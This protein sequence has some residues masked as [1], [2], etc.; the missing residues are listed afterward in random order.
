MGSGDDNIGERGEG[1]GRED[2]L[3]ADTLGLDNLV[4]KGAGES[5]DGAFGRGVVKE[6][7][8]QH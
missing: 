4:R 6:L 3:D 5:D 8:S 2:V 7:D 1:T